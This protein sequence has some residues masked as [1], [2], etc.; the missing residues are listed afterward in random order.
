MV[1]NREINGTEEIGL[2][3]PTPVLLDTV[4]KSHNGHRWIIPQSL[5][6]VAPYRG[7]DIWGVCKSQ[8]LLEILAIKPGNFVKNQ[9]FTRIWLWH[10]V[11]TYL[12]FVIPNFQFGHVIFMKK[13]PEQ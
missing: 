8:H 11:V 3:T 2:V 5:H 4:M 13:W 6:N 7:N 10:F 9:Y 12:V 1:K